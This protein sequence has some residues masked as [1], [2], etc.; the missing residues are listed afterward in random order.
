MSGWVV[1]VALGDSVT[2]GYQQGPGSRP[3]RHYPFTNVLESNLR[4]KL[5][6]LGAETDVAVENKGINGDSTFGMVNRFQRSVI[7]EKPDF[8]VIMG[9]LNDL[10]T[11]IPVDDVYRNLVQLTQ[12][13]KEAGA[14]PIMLST[15]PVAGSPDFNAKIKELNDR[16]AEY[17]GL[18]DVR[19][20]DLFSELLDDGVLAA[21]Y[22]NDGVHI[23]DKGYG[24][25]ISVL[26]PLF[27]ELVTG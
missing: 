1:F 22:S 18:N 9:G 5:K 13:T 4:M 3:P 24:K 17:C 7:P 16:V 23:S 27:L 25:I 6:A 21:E 11:R 15:T 10:F 8:V 20:I 2:A 12:L 14:E 26:A 19:F